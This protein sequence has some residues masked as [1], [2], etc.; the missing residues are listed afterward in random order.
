MTELFDT[1]EE[2]FEEQSRDLRE[3]IQQIPNSVGE[4][5]KKLIR[6]AKNILSDVKETVEVMQKEYG[7]SSNKYSK[8]IRMYRQDAKSLEQ[9]LHK[10]ENSFPN[11]RKERDELLSGRHKK[12]KERLG[13]R[14]KLL[15]SH[16]RVKNS[17]DSLNRSLRTSA[18][19]EEIGQEIL[20]ELHGQRQTLEETKDNLDEIDEEVDRGGKLISVMWRRAITNKLILIIVIIFLLALIGLIVYLSAFRKK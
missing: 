12:D 9:K 20:Q 2:D 1:L 18:Q 8:K 11:T 13:E 4:P 17:E 10:A 15:A 5:K 19:T 3:K 7:R 14:Q 16:Q 6:Q